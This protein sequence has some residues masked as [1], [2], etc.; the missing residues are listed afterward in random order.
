[1]LDSALYYSQAFRHL[2]LSDSNFTSCPS[3]SEWERVEKIS[4]LLKVFYDIT[5]VFSGSKYPISNLYF[6]V[7]AIAHLTLKEKL[8]SGDDFIKDLASKIYEK[9]I[10]NWADFSE[11]LAIACILDPR[12]KIHF[13]E[14][15]YKKIYG[16]GSQQFLTLKGKLFSLFD[17]YANERSTLVEK[18]TSKTSSSKRASENSTSLNFL[19]QNEGGDVII[20]VFLL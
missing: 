18:S 11:I 12:Y 16:A 15:S 10:K 6:P 4:K 13:V 19:Y 2:E 5:L 1:M 3:K 7:V 20:T 8:T 9:F 14:F 17:E